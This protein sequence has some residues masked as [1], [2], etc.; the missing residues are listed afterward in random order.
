MMKARVS[1]T[2]VLLMCA[3]LLLPPV[4]AGSSDSPPRPASGALPSMS[5]GAMPITQEPYLVR[6]INPGSASSEADL[7]IELNGEL[8]FYA[9]DGVNGAE[10]WKS[11][12]TP[13]GTV[14]VKDINPSGGSAP[15]WW[16]DEERIG[17]T[18]FFGANDGSTGEELWKTDGTPA[19]TVR[20]ADI[21]PGSGSSNPAYMTND[22]PAI[23]HLPTDAGAKPE[24]WWKLSR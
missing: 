14:L 9:D 21:N 10:L 6:D 8:L 24:E 3:T 11:D 19:G 20:V 2:L 7:L 17:S 5:S 18:V 15:V 4:T 22:S 23:T 1:T 12:G 16:S 13:A